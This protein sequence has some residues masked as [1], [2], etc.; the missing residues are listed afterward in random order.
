MIRIICEKGFY[1]F[2]PDSVDEI[3]RFSTKYGVDLVQCDDFYTFPVLAELPNY[4][5]IGQQYS[6]LIV[7]LA[8]YAA[9]REKVMAA[10]GLAYNQAAKN[11]TPNVAIIALNRQMNYIF[12]NNI[13]IDNLPQAYFRD[14]N[15]TITGFHGFVDVN[16]MKYNIERF[17]Y[18]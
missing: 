1:K 15:G 18:D 13:V 12:S 11:L 16:F 4:S 17:F 6:G 8:N 3:R 9:K 14:Q 7:G 10:N 2:F 5:F